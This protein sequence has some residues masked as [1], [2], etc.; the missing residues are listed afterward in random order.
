M[1]TSPS[2]K[3]VQEEEVVTEEVDPAK[4]TEE[5]DE[6]RT[7]EDQARTEEADPEKTTEEE[8]EVRTE[9]EDEV[10]TEGVDPTKTE[11][12]DPAKTTEEEDEVRT[13]KDETRTEEDEARTED[14]DPTKT[15]EKEDEVKTEEED[16][17][18]TEEDEV[19]TE[20]VDP[21]KKTEKEDEVRAEEDKA[22]TEEEEVRTEEEDEHKEEAIESLL[23]STRNLNIEDEESDQQ[24]E[25]Q[26][27]QED[28]ITTRRSD[29]AM[30]R[31]STSLASDQNRPLDSDPNTS[32]I[33]LSVQDQGTENQNPQE[34]SMIPR[35]GQR[36]ERGSTSSARYQNQNR[37]LALPNPPSSVQASQQMMM[38]PRLGPSVPPYQQNPYG[39]PQPRWL[40]V[41]H[42]YSDGLGLYGAQWR[43]RTITPFLPNQNTYPHQLVPMELP[44]QP[45]TE[46]VCYSQSFG[47]LRQGQLVPHQE[48]PP[49]RPQQQNQFRS[50]PPMRPMLP[51]DDFVVHLGQVPVRPM[52]YYQEQNQIVPNA[53][54]QAPARPSLPQVRVPMMQPPVLLYPPPIVNAVPVRPVM[55]QGGGQ[56]FRFPMI[57][58]HHGSPSAPWPEQNQ[59]LQSPRESQGS[60]DGPFSSGGSQD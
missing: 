54:I 33:S 34:Q 51:Q 37:P 38:P 55:N 3:L 58:Q 40:V 5:E 24:T 59:Q 15:I 47:V 35:S 44:G 25:N 12:V 21:T 16:E 43:F 27:R 48:A 23:E 29:Q 10:R 31:G 17:V 6:A 60:N 7:E 2:D 30:E 32:P 39:L 50:L 57:Q 46:L 9:E 22:R 45:G 36:M 14:V 1:A 20:E 18:R 49:M 41:D 4:T 56:R 26:N 53:G 13:K 28:P 52:M 8:D 42:F 19:R 11:E